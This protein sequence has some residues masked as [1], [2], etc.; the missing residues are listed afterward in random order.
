MLANHAPT[1]HR[2]VGH[3][4]L[5]HHLTRPS[6]PPIKYDP[7]D[8]DSNGVD[9]S[10]AVSSCMSTV[11]MDLN[12]PR[13]SITPSILST[14]PLPDGQPLNEQS[15]PDTITPDT[16]TAMGPTGELTQASTP[17]GDATTPLNKEEGKRDEDDEDDDESDEEKTSESEDDEVE[18]IQQAGP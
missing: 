2:V 13:G 8:S 14:K 16:V 18:E 12:T 9:A 5:Y 1:G 17:N 6:G 7:G 3:S 10:S 15:S 4:K 11:A